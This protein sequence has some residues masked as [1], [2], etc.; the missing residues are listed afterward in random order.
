M[1]LE[2]LSYRHTY[3]I[4]GV[5]DRWIPLIHLY[6]PDL[7][8]FPI[9]YFHTVPRK[10]RTSRPENR[11]RVYG[12]VESVFPHEGN[13][14][15]IRIITNKN[16]DDDINREFREAAIEEIRERIGIREPVTKKDVE[17]IFSEISPDADEVVKEIWERVVK[18][19]YGNTLPFGRLWDEVLGL[20]RF[21]ASW[22]S[23][24]GRKGELI[25]THYF[26]SRFGE[27]IQISSNL[28]QIDFY[29]LPTAAEMMDPDDPLRE[30]PSFRDLS[31][32]IR[33]F[34]D[35]NS[36]T[37][38]L[39]DIRISG[40]DN[41]TGTKLNT[42]LFMQLV[43]S[44]GLPSE[45]QKA[46]LECF[47]AFDKGPGRTLIFI[48]LLNDLRYNGLRPGDITSEQFG[49]LYTGIK[50]SY[51]SPKALAIYSQ[52][53]FANSDALPVDTWIET[54][55]KWPLSIF[56]YQRGINIATIFSRTRKLGR[57][58]RLLWV[59]SQARKV[60]SSACDDA[61]WCM[62]YNSE[63][64]PRGPNPLSCG[65][66][67]EPVRNSCPAFALISN[68]K[69]SFN[70]E[71][72]GSDFTIYTD[73]GNNTSPGQAFVK[74][75]GNS[76]YGPVMDDFSPK[77]DPDG[78]GSFPHSKHYGEAITVKRFVELY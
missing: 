12:Y 29:L 62:K 34:C 64:K 73:A 36:R 1:T 17:G 6:D 65:I 25:Q 23:P 72:F 43:Q 74:C 47:N 59:T 26:A 35:K 77:D 7:P 21:V 78:L 27:K 33:K 49:Q 40:F 37:F 16:L 18:E 45:E 2:S 9:Y 63:S 42:S 51:N 52:Q 30:F 71:E 66:C 75:T 15:Q 4:D 50:G 28:P 39:D 31:S 60:H 76:L 48:L 11:N 67:Y 32:F 41:R 54:F 69:V 58:E 19:A 57:L 68:K 8:L 10:L 22:D 13:H 61:L 3:T 53:C 5:P 20:A 44:L 38:E 14:L 46:A 24:S 55:L 70:E 56:P